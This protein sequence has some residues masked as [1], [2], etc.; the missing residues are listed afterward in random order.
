ME[1]YPISEVERLTGIK[2]H[3]L[4]VWEKRYDGMLPHRT[5]TNIRYYDDD[6]LRKLLNISTLVAAGFKIS[7]LFGLDEAG[8]S[9]LILSLKESNSADNHTTAFINELTAAMS[10]FDEVAFD[11]T[12]SA[13]LARFGMYD[14]MIKVVYPFLYNTGMLWTISNLMPAEE[15][16]ASNI[17]RRKLMAAVDS[18]PPAGAK[19]KLFVLSLPTDEFHDIGILFTDY[20]IRSSGH[21]TIYLGQN[22]PNSSLAVA[23]R[24][25]KPAHVLTFLVQSHDVVRSLEEFSEL[26]KSFPDIDILVCTRHRELIPSDVSYIKVLSAPA[27]IFTYLRA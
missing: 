14:S 17:I 15:H 21:R 16:F 5:A 27:D 23:M 10:A 6:Q 12:F 18:L 7:H 13:M 2:A 3:T 4:R 1:I 24:K 20:I 19:G 22:V 11:K 9:Q 25:A 26:A 8:I